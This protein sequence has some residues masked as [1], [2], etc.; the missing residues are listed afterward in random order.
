MGSEVIKQLP[1]LDHIDP[2]ERMENIDFQPLPLNWD[3]GI[4]AG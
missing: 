4:A 2:I 1:T 3:V